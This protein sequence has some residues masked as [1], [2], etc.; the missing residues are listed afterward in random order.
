M[1]IVKYL[2]HNAEATYG[3]CSVELDEVHIA[4]HDGLFIHQGVSKY[5][6][7][8]GY[9]VS[10]RSHSLDSPGKAIK[11]LSALL[12][13]FAIDPGNFFIMYNRTHHKTANWQ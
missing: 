5:T 2:P 1:P 6:K 8:A 9:K 4:S 10:S 3:Y 13:D 7:M 11:A 12:V